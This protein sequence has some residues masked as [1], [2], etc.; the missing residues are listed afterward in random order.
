MSHTHTHY[1][2]YT[3]TTCHIHPL[4]LPHTRIQHAT[5]THPTCHIQAPNMPHT[6]PVCHIHAPTPTQ[7][8]AHTRAPK[9]VGPPKDQ[10][11]SPRQSEDIKPFPPSQQLSRRHLGYSLATPCTRHGG[12]AVRGRATL[13]APSASITSISV[14][15]EGR[16]CSQKS[17]FNRM[18]NITPWIIQVWLSLLWAVHVVWSIAARTQ[19]CTE[20]NE[21]HPTARGL[22]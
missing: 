13:R 9:R 19:S 14:R 1:A 3:H 7:T 20:S 16:E 2:T 8:H 6:H 4:S 10:V 11:S 21:Y 5:Y 15:G 22:L 17:A 12:V 18:E